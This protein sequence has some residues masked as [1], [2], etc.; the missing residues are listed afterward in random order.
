[1]MLT[2]TRANYFTSVVFSISLPVAEMVGTIAL[3]PEEL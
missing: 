1:M 3:L 2:I